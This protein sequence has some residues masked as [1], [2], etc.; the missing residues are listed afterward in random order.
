MYNH[1][2]RADTIDVHRS[3]HDAD[4]LD[5]S[6]HIPPGG[7]TNADQ[8]RTVPAAVTFAERM[9]DIGKPVALICH[10]PWLLVEADLVR[11]RKLRHQV[12]AAQH[13]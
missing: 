6:A 7:V 1:L 3:I 8:L 5:Y 10:G 12:S 2:D 11:S 9:S 13:G 4:A